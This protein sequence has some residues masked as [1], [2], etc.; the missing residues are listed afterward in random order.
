[1]FYIT[2]WKIIN[3]QNQPL[4]IVNKRKHFIDLEADITYTM[5]IYITHITHWCYIGFSLLLSDK[6][7]LI[8]IRTLMT[9]GV[10]IITKACSILGWVSIGKIMLPYLMAKEITVHP[11]P[12]FNK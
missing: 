4:T 12:N 3:K 7:S 9:T 6:L 10:E 1:M 8:K 11:A 2:F 5:H